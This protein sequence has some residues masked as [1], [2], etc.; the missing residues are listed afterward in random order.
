M[1]DGDLEVRH[2][3][4]GDTHR[5]LLRGVD[6]NARSAQGPFVLFE[7]VSGEDDEFAGLNAFE[8]SPHKSVAE[9]AGSAGDED[10]FVVDHFGNHH[11]R[12]ELISIGN[13]LRVSTT[14]GIHSAS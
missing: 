10:A 8:A 12:T 14:H 5:A 9:G 3:T 4:V 13:A 11:A 2:A 6:E 7:F 1:L